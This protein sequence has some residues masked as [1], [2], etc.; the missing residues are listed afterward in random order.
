M[1]EKT[2]CENIFEVITGTTPS[3]KNEEYWEPEINW[4][5]PTDLSLKENN[6]F[7]RSSIRKIS[8][9]AKEHYKLRVLPPNS[10]V[11]S[12]RAPVGYVAVL[13]ENA[14]INQGCK[15][16]VP[17]IREVEPLFYA[18]YFKSIREK[19]EL[20][21]AG[22][23]FKEL[24]K[25]TLENLKIPLPPLP[26]QKRIAEVL[27][28]VDEAILKVEQEIEHTERLKR[29]LMQHLLSRGIGHTH[30]KDSPIGKIP[31]EWDVVRLGEV[32]EYFQY[33]F[34]AKAENE[35]VGPKFLRI[36]DIQDGKV[37]WSSVPYC[38]ID[39]NLLKKFELKSGDILFARIGATTGKSFLIKECPKTIFASYLIRCRVN[40]NKA[41]PEF[42]F[43]YTQ[44]SMYWN[45]IHSIK[46]GRLKQGINL[47]QIQGLLIP[48]PPLPEQKRIAEI[49]MTVDKKLELLRQ[50]KEHLE[51]I[52]KG[53]MNDLLTGKKRLKVNLEGDT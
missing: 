46:G 24:S 4:I 26:E 31:E 43:I 9:K 22:S 1:W 2:L 12:T 11:I 29:G 40:L 3:T 50:K 7:I 37:N 27:R 18:Y 28:T 48:L 42:L 52:K 49:L 13:R 23:T 47:P 15:G 51:R 6:L 8:Q 41:F 32:A 34:T 30:F 39:D 35:P 44:S 14:T 53:L 33:G 45:Q 16:L 36:T 38:R 25:E 21:S 19:L 17:K 20:L 5:T 10:I